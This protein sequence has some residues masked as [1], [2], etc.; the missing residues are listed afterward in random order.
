MTRYVINKVRLE[1]EKLGVLVDV[2]NIEGFKAESADLSVYGAVGFAYPVHSFNAPEI[3]TGFAKRLPKT[4][5]KS[6]F[7]I[8]TAGGESPANYASSRLLINILSKKGFD[9]FYN[10]QFIMPSNFMVKDGEAKVSQNIAAAN[11]AA[12]QTAQE[13]INCTEF[14]QPKSFAALVL[15]FFGRAEQ[16][17]AKL[18]GKFFYAD[19][20]CSMCGICAENCPNNNITIDSGRMKFKSCCGLCMRCL[21]MC[22]NKS[23]KVRRPFKFIRFDRWYDNCEF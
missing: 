6:A 11:E 23:L 1:L 17:C 2:H 15:Q 8:S 12:P 16:P 14:Q 13:I 7:I 3:V 20:N 9:V 4:D 10:R 19:E 21:Y 18:M 5:A 22:P